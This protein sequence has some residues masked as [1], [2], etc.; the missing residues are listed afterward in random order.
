MVS[1]RVRKET[2]K[3]VGEGECGGDSEKGGF[4]DLFLSLEKSQIRVD[5]QAH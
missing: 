5:H 3:S 2:R 1:E 4:S